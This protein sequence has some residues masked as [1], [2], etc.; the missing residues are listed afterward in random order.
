MTNNVKRSKAGESFADALASDPQTQAAWGRTQLRLLAIGAG[1]DALRGPMEAL[2]A[3]VR[4]TLAQW[5]AETDEARSE[6]AQTMREVTAELEANR[7][8]WEAKY[9]EPYPRG[10]DDW[11]REALRAG[12]K[13]E[14][15]MTKATLSDMRVSIEAYLQRVKD[16]HPDAPAKRAKGDPTPAETYAFRL[17]EYG[18]ELYKGSAPEKNIKPTS[19]GVYEALK[20]ERDAER[21]NPNAHSAFNPRHGEDGLPT[22]KTLRTNASRYRKKKNLATLNE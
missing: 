19:K 13:R 22:L 17:Y 18:V 16:W 20:R 4:I 10:I 15:I 2:S 3:I 8:E 12:E 1:M 7:E 21:S 11:I 14:W 5:K 6:L 9:G